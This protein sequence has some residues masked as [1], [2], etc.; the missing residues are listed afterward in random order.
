[1]EIKEKLAWYVKYRTTIWGVI[2]FVVGLVGGNVDR[3]QEN[4]PNPGGDIQA[5]EVRVEKLEQEV[6]GEQNVPSPD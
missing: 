3:L 4:L 5:L 2:W 1:M 6:F